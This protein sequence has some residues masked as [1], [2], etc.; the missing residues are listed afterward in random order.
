VPK[1]WSASDARANFADLLNEAASG[2]VQTIER[3]DG[4][5]FVL[6]SKQMFMTSR[7]SLAHYLADLDTGLNEQE[8]EEWLQAMRDAS[9]KD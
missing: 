5:E 6:V 9:G 3:R 1:T 8:S 7:P 4:S 2:E